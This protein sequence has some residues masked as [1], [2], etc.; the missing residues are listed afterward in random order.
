M[1]L[2]PIIVLIIG[3]LLAIL[4]PLILTMGNYY[5][6]FDF[7]NTGQI[8]DTIGGL[9]SPVV[10][11]ISAII[12]Y[13]SFNEQLKAN[14][15]QSDALKDE[16]DRLN[17]EKEFN[18]IT[19]LLL[20][21]ERKID[22]FEFYKELERKTL[23]AQLDLEN[24]ISVDQ[25][26]LY[27][28]VN[29]LTHFSKYAIRNWQNSFIQADKT[30]LMKLEYFPEFYFLIN[31]VNYIIAEIENSKYIDSDSKGKLFSRTKYVFKYKLETPVSVILTAYSK[32]NDSEA[33]DLF[34]SIRKIFEKLKDDQLSYV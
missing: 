20:E 32:L 24:G 27:K 18:Y 16:K 4:A 9:T 21:L 22:N 3:I 26:T 30:N 15:I 34:K 31:E 10:N 1:K 8:G 12:I 2:P 13:Y 33:D 19:Q 28:G 29:A 11:L 23:Q 6:I 17:Y 5:K 14:K 7:S 25:K